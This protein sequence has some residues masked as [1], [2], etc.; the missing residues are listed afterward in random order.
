MTKREKL[1]SALKTIQEHCIEKSGCDECELRSP[2]DNT[3]CVLDNCP[4][5]WVFCNENYIP[6]I[7][8]EVD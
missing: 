8:V 4:T 3:I 1:L 5:T 6:P 2:F 7:V